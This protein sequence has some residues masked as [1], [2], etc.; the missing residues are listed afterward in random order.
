MCGRF[1]MTRR[2]KTELA[3]QL[4]VPESELGDYTPRFNIAPTQ[5]YFVLKTTY[6]SRE[7]I[8]ATWGLVNSWATDAGQAAKCINA[9]AETV[10]KLP[11]YREAFKRRRCVV[12]AD[13]FYEW[14]GRSEADLCL[15]RSSHENQAEVVIDHLAGG[16]QYEVRGDKPARAGELTFAVLDSPHHRPMLQRRVRTFA[17]EAHPDSV[18]PKRVIGIAE[19]NRADLAERRIAGERHFGL[20]GC[21]PARYWQQHSCQAIGTND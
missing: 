6:E 18:K 5:P 8:P 21:F 3:A 20:E 13:G 15:E 1:T 16:A 9:R 4:G 10:H 2:D 7:V 12:P 17:K 14:R 19:A 11:S